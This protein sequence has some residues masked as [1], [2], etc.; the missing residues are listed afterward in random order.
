MRAAPLV[1]QLLFAAGL[2][3]WTA[4]QTTMLLNER[5]SLKTLRANQ[6]ATVQQ[7]I[8]LRA[9]LDSIAAKTQVLADRGNAGAR[10]IVDEL[11]KRGVTIDPNAK[12]AQAAN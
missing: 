1:P 8:K 7:S 4:F 12:P 5:S 11:R 3:I 6:E 9:Q 10:T 2:V